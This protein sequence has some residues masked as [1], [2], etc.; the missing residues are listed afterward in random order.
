[1]NAFFQDQGFTIIAALLIFVLTLVLGGLLRPVF[2][3]LGQK[4]LGWLRGL[5]STFGREYQ[6]HLLE[7]YRI[8]NIRGRKTKSPVSLELEQVY[9]SLRTQLPAGQAITPRA[10]SE[11]FT[12]G[13]A[14]RRAKRL[15]IIGG[16]GSGKTTLLTYL[17]LTY[18]RGLPPQRLEL[19]ETRLPIFVPLRQLKTV[20]RSEQPGNLPDYLS[21]TYTKL[22]LNPLPGF[23]ENKLKK[24]ECLV[25]LDGLDEVADQTERVKMAEWVDA[26]ITIYPDNRFIVTSRPA[27][28]DT[29]ALENNF[30]RLDVQDFNQADIEQFCHNWCLTVE[31]TTQGQDNDTVRRRASQAAH[32]LVQAIAGNPA[33]RT[34]AINPLLLSI[35]ALVHRYRATLPRRRVELY[36]ECVDVLLGQWD[37]AKGLAGRLTESQKRAVLQPVALYMHQHNSREIDASTLRA[38]LKQH[39]PTVGGKPQEAGQFLV[40]IRDRSGLLLEQDL[41]SYTFS[42]LTFQEYLVAR[43]LADNGPEQLLLTQAGVE[44]WQEVTL[45][46]TGL[47]NAGPV[48]EAL[49]KQEET[50]SQAPLLLAGRCLLDAQKIEPALKQKTIQHLEALF[51][52][53]TG[54]PFLQAGHILADLAESQAITRFL[55][56]V[57]G[58]NEARRNAARWALE[59]MLN[60]ENEVQRTRYRTQL[61]EVAFAPKSGLVEPALEILVELAQ[62]DESISAEFVPRLMEAAFSSNSGLVEPALE[63]LTMLALQDKSVSAEFVP[64]LMDVAFMPNSGLAE[65]TLEALTTL[66][67]QDKSVSAE[68]VPRL[69]DVA[70]TPN[71][72]LAESALEALTMLALQDKSVSAEFVPRLMEAAL[73]LNSGLVEPATRTLIELAQQDKSILAELIQVAFTSSSKL[74]KPAINILTKLTQQDESIYAEVI[75]RLM[76]AA[77]T[78][79]SGLVEPALE[80][81]VTLALQDKSVSAE[82]VPRLMEA[83]LTLNSGL[84]K[85]SVKTLTELA[86]QDETILTEVVPRLSDI[87]VKRQTA[88]SQAIVG[89]LNDNRLAPL[90][91]DWLDQL[92]VEVPKK[93]VNMARYPV[94]NAQYRRFVEGDGYRDERWWSKAGWL[95]RYKP[96]DYRQKPVLAPEYWTNEKWNGP[97]LPVVGVSWYE[98]EAYCN[99]LTEY[100]GRPYRLPQEAEWQLAVQGNDKREYPW[101][102]D[103]QAGRCNTSDAGLGQTSPV[104]QFSPAGDSSLGCADM[105]GNVWEWCSDWYDKK[106]R[107]CR[108]LRGGSWRSNQVRARCADRS[109]YYPHYSNDYYGFRVVSPIF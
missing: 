48:V 62:Q 25:L 97:M 80:A 46:Y 43:E 11:S 94:T 105:S 47:K 107:T 96:P 12:I 65:P 70:F 98:A 28:Y 52:H 79:N 102:N 56:V 60:D 26:Q 91:V 40:E 82:F 76:E 74:A 51:K 64:R 19:T 95:W 2:E 7:E 34:L 87:V 9:V 77:L 73:T 103:W 10:K 37:Q 17:L 3:S 16:P 18:A 71:S 39:L 35:I 24:G 69:M 44:W 61:V 38:Q 23:F 84:V 49:L 108:V 100:T 32:D 27:G 53:G 106:E 36:A 31:L 83:A 54:Q 29:A 41:N 85:P 86:Q 75:P 13:H 1:M 20:L 104:G 63:A 88:I 72:R 55:Q 8:M 14:L 50:E 67:L 30:L 57:G 90:V 15:V 59:Q 21:Q 93:S 45:L 33:V 68:F 5:G 89:L 92:M 78:P 81:L 101:G 66:A 99:W 58:D 22:G 4:L 109:R 42:H 6:A